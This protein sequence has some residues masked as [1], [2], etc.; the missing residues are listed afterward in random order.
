MA[1]ANT[2]IRQRLSKSHYMWRHVETVVV[3]RHR[4][5]REVLGVHHTVVARS[6]ARCQQVGTKWRGAEKRLLQE[7]LDLSANSGTKG[8]FC[9][10]HPAS[11]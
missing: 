8:L 4:E 1:N 11:W 2:S 6:W 5:V 3:D 7:V 10:R 9:N